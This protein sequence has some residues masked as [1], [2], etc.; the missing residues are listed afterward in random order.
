MGGQTY[1]PKQ[2]AEEAARE[3]QEAADERDAYRARQ[4]FG[5]V[6]SGGNSSGRIVDWRNMPARR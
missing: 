6:S 5:L 3:K 4:L 2:T 1:V